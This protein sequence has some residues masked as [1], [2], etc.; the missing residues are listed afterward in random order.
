MLE[1]IVV[2]GLVVLR[3]TFPGSIFVQICW[4]TV[5]TLDSF[6]YKVEKMVVVKYYK[7]TGLHV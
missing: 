7:I 4:Y 5:H 6:K 2:R 1:W 3:H